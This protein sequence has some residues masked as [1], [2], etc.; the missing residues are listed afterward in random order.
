M[1][2]LSFMPGSEAEAAEYEVNAG[3]VVSINLV[4]PGEGYDTVKAT[5]NTDSGNVM[6]SGI[7]S[8]KT[9]WVAE[10]YGN[11]IVFY[12]NSGANPLKD[13]ETTAVLSFRL[14]DDMAAGTKST[15]S[16]NDITCYAGGKEYVKNSV[17]YTFVIKEEHTG[18]AELLGIS[19]KGYT[20]IPE[21]NP[22]VTEYSIGSVSYETGYI[23]VTANPSHY[24]ADVVITGNNLLPGENRI[25]IRV[26]AD[27]GNMKEYTVKV[28]RN[29]KKETPDSTPYEYFSLCLKE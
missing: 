18:D 1:L 23:D 24:K 13:G 26:T 11:N 3:D 22:D 29:E 14:N 27:N 20:L 28:T 17:E 5:V 2:I 6:L 19:V 8:G 10:K 12:D 21:F 9:D 15:V 7:S 16:I 4:I 25:L